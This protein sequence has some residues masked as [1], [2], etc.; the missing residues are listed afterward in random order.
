MLAAQADY[1]SRP[2]MTIWNTVDG[3]RD[4]EVSETV[5]LGQVYDLLQN[6]KIESVATLR[7]TDIGEAIK[8]NALLERFG[9]S[10][11]ADLPEGELPEI[12]LT[13]G[14]LID[15]IVTSPEFEAHR[16]DGYTFRSTV[17]GLIEAAGEEK[18]ADILQNRVA[19]ASRNSSYDNTRDNIVNYWMRLLTF[20][21]LFALF[22]TI[23]LEFIDKD[24]R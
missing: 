21:F 11:Q 10:D 6:E 13:K 3:M 1:N 14:D 18:V 20:V 8:L 24:K 15:A 16:S 9:I 7:N 23:T 4:R 2:V 5:T 17:G 12:H 19:E 22:S